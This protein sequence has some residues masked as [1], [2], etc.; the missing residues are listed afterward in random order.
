[1]HHLT[2]MI[3]H[4]TAFVTPV[5]DHWLEREIASW[6]HPMKDISTSMHAYIHTYIDVVIHQYILARARFPHRVKHVRGGP[7][8]FGSPRISSVH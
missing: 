5:V 2:D 3:V 8:G 4:T 1:M 7:R 6:V